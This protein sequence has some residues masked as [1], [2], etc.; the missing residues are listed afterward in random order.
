MPPRVLGTMKRAVL[1]RQGTVIEVLKGKRPYGGLACCR[2][3]RG[4]NLSRKA[5]KPRQETPLLP[6]CGVK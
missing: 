5:A 2:P 1:R 4:K 3:V 6:E